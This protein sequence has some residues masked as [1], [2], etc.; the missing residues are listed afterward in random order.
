MQLNEIVDLL[1][2]DILNKPSIRE[3]SGICCNVNY[4]KNGDL[5]FAHNKNDIAEAINRGAYGVIFDKNVKI[6]NKEVAFIKVDDIQKSK[7]K[8]IK[9]MI[10]IGQ[11]NILFLYNDELLI[12]NSIYKYCFDVNSNMEFIDFLN[13]KI[14]KNDIKLIAT[15][16]FSLMDLTSHKIFILQ[17][18]L[19]YDLKSVFSIVIRGIHINLPRYFEPKINQLISIF[20]KFNIDINLNSLSHAKFFEMLYVDS[21][22]A[23]IKK[24]NSAILGIQNNMTNNGNEESF[25]KVCNFYKKYAKHL[26]I[27]IF[28][29]QNLEEIFNALKKE[30]FNLALIYNVSVSVIREFLEKKESLLTQ[31]KLFK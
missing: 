7:Y 15:N 28:T 30:S 9:Y 29:S 25:M 21:R 12:A 26:K 27:V 3:F 17:N 11:F 6:T 10:L 14:G 19:K 8:L 23:I 16:D 24:S 18:N 13:L 5:F 31:N 1:Y 4:V 22:I 20:E 2:A